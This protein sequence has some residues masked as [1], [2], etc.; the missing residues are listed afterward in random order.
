MINYIQNCWNVVMN[1]KYN[2]LSRIPDFETR[3]LVFQLLA[4]M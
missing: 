3:H 1:N 4:W 2:P